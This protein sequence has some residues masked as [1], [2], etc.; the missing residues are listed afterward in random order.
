MN[1]R[2]WLAG[3]LGA[4]STAAVAGT[5]G[6]LAASPPQRIVV[7][8]W[9]L[10]EMLLSI[11]VVPVGAA[12]TAGFLRSFPASTLPRSVV[13]LGLMFQPNMELL[14]SL[15]PDL[16]VVSP[17]HAALCTSLERIAP[18]VTFGRY[19]S[20]A[21]PYT[22]ARAETLQLARMLD[23]VPRADALLAHA[24]NVLD[25]ARARLAA[26]PRV[27]DT[28]L[29][30][31][32]FLD[33]THLRV[34]GLHSLFGELFATLGLRNAWQGATRSGAYAT[35]AFDALRPAFG[36]TLLYQKPLPLSVVNMMNTSPLWAA[37]PFVRSGRLIGMPAV[38]AEGSV[39]SA[40]YFVRVLVDALE[41]VTP[42]HS[43]TATPSLS[44]ARDGA[45]EGRA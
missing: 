21:T 34:Y 7:L 9:A 3:L 37:Q 30:M 38:P 19:R 15:K 13:D 25:E 17:A 18:T 44:D 28:P 16:I 29:Y 40:I 24:S 32:R 11:G 20:S 22:D 35:I 10:T 41:Q 45:R 5:G 4:V 31:V 23:C 43:L 1:R 8:D 12:N 2:A 6:R 14:L 27:R 26:L 36:T 39:A 33:E 42:H